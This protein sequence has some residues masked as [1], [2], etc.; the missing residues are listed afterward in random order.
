MILRFHPSSVR[1]GY[2]GPR[3]E[4]L[5]WPFVTYTESRRATDKTGK[6]DEIRRLSSEARRSDCCVEAAFYLS[7]QASFADLLG[8]GVIFSVSDA[9]N[10]PQRDDF[11][12]VGVFAVERRLWDMTF[13]VP[14]HGAGNINPF[15]NH[16][17]R[18]QMQTCP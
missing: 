2:S 4:P 8:V 10:M 7:T 1:V 13:S 6:S 3:R 12:A 15:Q 16:L 9:S 17:A 14:S 5:Y 18:R 11:A